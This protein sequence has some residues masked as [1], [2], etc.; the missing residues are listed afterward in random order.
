MGAMK[1]SMPNKITPSGIS[2]GIVFFVVFW[3]LFDSLALGIGLG[4]AM[5]AAFSQHSQTTNEEWVDG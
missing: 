1:S 3:L 2:M 4:F 5:A